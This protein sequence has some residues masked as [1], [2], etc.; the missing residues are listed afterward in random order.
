MQSGAGKRP[1]RFWRSPSAWPQP[2]SSRCRWKRSLGR[3][4]PFVPSAGDV[5]AVADT[6][7]LLSGL[8]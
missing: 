4:K 8:F 6:N 7:V 3:S 5:R 2:A 1:M